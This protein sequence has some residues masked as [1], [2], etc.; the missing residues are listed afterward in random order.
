MMAVHAAFVL[1]NAAMKAF[2]WLA[3]GAAGAVAA[4]TIAASTAAAAIREQQTAMYAFKGG[5]NYQAASVMMRQLAGDTDLASAGAAKARHLRRQVLVTVAVV[6]VSFLLRAVSATL[7]AVARALQNEAANCPDSSACSLSCRNV[8]SLMLIW[9][10]YRPAFQLLIILL[11]SPL[12]LLV[13]L[14]G[15]TNKRMLELMNTPRAKATMMT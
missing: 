15:M 5:G 4:L 14:W 6:F 7:N 13:A 1:G 2:N 11:S 12:A 8:Y 10:L 3:G 9:I